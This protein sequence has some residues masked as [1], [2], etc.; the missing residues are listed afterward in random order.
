M[1]YLS[2]ILF[3][4]LQYEVCAFGQS[5]WNAKSEELYL[6]ISS[7]KKLPSAEIGDS[8]YWVIVKGGLDNM[9]SLIELLDNSQ[10]T[11]VHAPYFG[12]NY[13][14]ADLAFAIIT[15]IV[16]YMDTYSLLENAGCKIDKIK[17]FLNYWEYL[18]GNEG[19]RKRFKNSVR[20]WYINNKNGLVWFNT[21]RHAYSDVNE[22]TPFKNPAGGYYILKKK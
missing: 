4:I 17:G 12:R 10:I 8:I 16:F 7:I 1:R 6:Q 13:S 22:L 5:A 11:D 20:Q 19:N 2:L 9:P 15:D 21:D 3:F 18:E 14:I